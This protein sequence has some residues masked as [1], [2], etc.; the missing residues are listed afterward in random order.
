MPVGNDV[1]F[2]STI[3]LEVSIRSRGLMNCP[4]C[5]NKTKVKKLPH[6][7]HFEKEIKILSLNFTCKYCPYCELLIAKKDKIENILRS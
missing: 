5:N 6:A 2:A 1:K 7:V 4:K 3:S